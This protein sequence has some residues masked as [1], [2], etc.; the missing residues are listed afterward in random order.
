MAAC[1]RS[2]G[3]D[4]HE[5]KKKMEEFR[6]SLLNSPTRFQRMSEREDRSDMPTEMLKIEAMG[7]GFLHHRGCHILKTTSDQAIVK[8]MF[9]IVR[10]ATI[11]ELGAFTG[12]SAVLMADNL[13][14]MDIDCHIYSVDIDL[15]LI[16][17]RMKDIKPDNVTFMQGD[18]NKIADIFPKQDLLELPHPWVVIEDVHQDLCGIMEYFFQFM[19]SGDYFII[20]DTSPDLPSKLGAGRIA[21][22]ITTTGNVKLMKLREFSCKHEGECAVDSFFCDFFGYNVTWN[23]NGFIKRM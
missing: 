19:K 18:V 6:A 17:P 22:N 5:Y 12:G 9:N 8:E 14:M 2:V 1:P 4:Y 13:K 3:K 21:E 20:E 16:D 10:P 15:S 11:I 23:W 7:R